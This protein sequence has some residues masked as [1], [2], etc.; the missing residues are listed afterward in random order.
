M[1]V[2]VFDCVKLWSCSQIQLFLLDHL[3]GVISESLCKVV[4][5]FF[6]GVW[7]H[8]LH[9]SGFGFHVDFRPDVGWLR[10]ELYLRRRRL[11]QQAR[12]RL[13]LKQWRDLYRW[14]YGSVSNDGTDTPEAAGNAANAARAGTT[15]NTARA[16]ST[17][18]SGITTTAFRLIVVVVVSID[19]S[20]S[21]T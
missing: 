4:V 7:P 18:V 3:P 19:G 20:I 11:N 8:V 17:T 16:A 5:H 6:L 13:D 10:R 9:G 15:T 21:V 12:F 14:D 1:C 2:Y